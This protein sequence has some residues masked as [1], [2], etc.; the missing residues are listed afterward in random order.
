[1]Q[2]VFGLLPGRAQVVARIDKYQLALPALLVAAAGVLV[3][4]M[5]IAPQAQWATGLWVAGAAIYQA[6]CPGR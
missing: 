2:V 5:K 1:M 3:V 4:V 6:Q